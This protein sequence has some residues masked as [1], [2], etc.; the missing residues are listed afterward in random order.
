MSK[1]RFSI[2]TFFTN[3]KMKILKANFFGENNSLWGP[4]QETINDISIYYMYIQINEILENS[5]EIACIFQKVLFSLVK[6]IK[7]VISLA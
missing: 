4:L 1:G 5:D 6:N 2:F 3:F 7:S